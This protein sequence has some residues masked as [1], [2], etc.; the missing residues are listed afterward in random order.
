MPTEVL[1]IEQRIKLQ[2]KKKAARREAKR[3]RREAEAEDSKAPM[4]AADGVPPPKDCI[5]QIDR[6]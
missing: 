2:E 5:S 1:S 6:A 4:E 3:L